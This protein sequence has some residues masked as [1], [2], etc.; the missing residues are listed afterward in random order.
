MTDT[1]DVNAT[2]SVFETA[3]GPTHEADGFPEWMTTAEDEG[4]TTLVQLLSHKAPTGASAPDET[5][6]DVLGFAPTMQHEDNLDTLLSGT[7]LFTAESLAQF[8]QHP[9]HGG[10]V[11]LAGTGMPGMVT[12]REGC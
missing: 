9:A 6:G 8:Q 10:G 3:A 11:E 1:D 4:N 7:F 2:T 12:C 5:L